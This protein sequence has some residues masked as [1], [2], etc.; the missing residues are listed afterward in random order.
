MSRDAFS[1]C[2]PRMTRLVMDGLEEILGAAAL[3]E[4]LA[5]ARCNGEGAS[6]FAHLRAGLE[7]RYSVEAANGVLLRT[8]RAVFVGLLRSYAVELGFEEIE[9]RLLAPRKR[10]LQGLQ[11]L[12]GFLVAECGSTIQVSNHEGFWRW[13]AETCL[14]CAGLSQEKPACYFT[15]GM[16]QEFMLWVSSGRIHPLR[17]CEC[18]ANGGKACI[19]EIEQ[20]AL[21]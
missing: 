15:L 3:E 4:V 7:Q 10:I 16:L 20:H 13:S 19:I 21:D 8:G 14:E 12:A 1:V 9:Y 17:E 11:Q 2:S 18:R 5:Q 6:T